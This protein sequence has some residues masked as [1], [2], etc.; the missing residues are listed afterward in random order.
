MTLRG[1]VGQCPELGQA[2]GRGGRKAKFF[3]FTEPLVARGEMKHRVFPTDPPVI[4]EELRQH[5][6]GDQPPVPRPVPSPAAGSRGGDGDRA[7]SET[8]QLAPWSRRVVAGR[9]GGSASPR[10]KFLGPERCNCVQL[11]LVCQ[12]AGRRGAA[13]R[14]PRTG[15]AGERREGCG[16]G[17]ISTP[18]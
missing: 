18:R 11:F 7:A 16:L 3:R 15:K 17:R 1:R 12:A 10:G 4:G 8:G 5:R 13:S 9:P 6:L 14:E 2:G